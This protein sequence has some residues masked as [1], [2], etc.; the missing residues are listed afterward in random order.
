[1]CSAPH[2]VVGR[3]MTMCPEAE[4]RF[5]LASNM[6]HAL[7]KSEQDN[8]ENPEDIRNRMVKEYT[9]P[10]AGTN[11][12][13]PDILRPPKILL[14]TV[15]YLVNLYKREK[16]KQFNLVYNFVCDRFRAVRQDMILQDISA[17][18]ALRI[19]EAMIPFYLETDYICRTRNCDVYDWKLHSTQMEECLSRWAEAMEVVPY[20]SASIPTLCA[21][22]LQGIPSSTAL[23]DLY[24]WKRYL[25]YNIFCILRDIIIAFRG[26]N[27]VRFFRRLSELP[28]D[29][30]VVAA[31]EAVRILRQRALYTITTAYKSPAVKIPKS[32]L[33]RWLQYDDISDI[34][35]HLGVPCSDF[36]PI[37]S[38]DLSAIPND[39]SRKL[40]SVICLSKSNTC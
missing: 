20:D 3:C 24:A 32:T 7:E 25:D 31:V 27:Y 37:S 10:A 15:R 35:S 22:I 8:S 9:R 21:Y 4:I 33:G 13:H 19:L 12:L 11:H 1:M 39:D 28:G 26:N 6:V 18:E 17:A 34:L 23:Q 30:T 2:S 40:L 16:A 5:R 38:I 36:V 29:I 14:S